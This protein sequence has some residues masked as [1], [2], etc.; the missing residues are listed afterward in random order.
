MNLQQNS[1][2]C[3]DYHTST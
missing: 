1:R 2:N 3:Q